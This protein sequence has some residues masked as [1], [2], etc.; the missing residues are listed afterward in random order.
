LRGKRD[1]SSSGEITDF[2]LILDCS[3]S[4]MDKTKEGPS[5]MEVAKKVVSDLIDKIP[6][7]RR[8]TFI[9]YGH[10]VE[11]KGQAVKVV[12]PLSELDDAGKAD[13]KRAIAVLR[14]AGHTPIA[15]ALQVAG[16]E[17]TKNDANCGVILITDG[18]ETCHGNPNAEAA[19]LA[20]NPKLTF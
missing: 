7:G 1:P 19:K 2:A 17:L 12:R 13:L 8:L 4:M 11:E 5:K 15:L 16:K 9:I 20:A 18:M 14:P 3:G 10:N 6:S